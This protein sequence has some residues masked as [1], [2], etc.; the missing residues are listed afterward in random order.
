MFIYVK[1]L[2]YAFLAAVGFAVIFNS[3]KTT[4]IKAG[5]NGSIGWI[6]FALSKDIF[7]SS[8]VASFV[9]ALTVGIVGEVFAKIFKKPSTTFIIP[10]IIPLVPGAGIYYTML[11]LTKQS[12]LNAAEAGSQTLLVSI[13]LAS[14]I[15]ISSSLNR[16]IVNFIEA[17][18]MEK[19]SKPLKEK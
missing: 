5:I 11:A 4:L 12:F 9:A 1:Q 7:S 14:G 15:V 18:R 19:R 2:L 17:K 13:S 8:V 6:V 10:G 16:A 3:P